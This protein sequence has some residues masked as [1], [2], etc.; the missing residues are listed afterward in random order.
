M[1]SI[2]YRHRCFLVLT[3]ASCAFC[4]TMWHCLDMDIIWSK[5]GASEHS[6]LLRRPDAHS[7]RFALDS[8]YGRNF[9]FPW[10]DRQKG[11]NMSAF[12][13]VQRHYFL[14]T[15]R[16]NNTTR[17]VDSP[18][19]LYSLFEPLITQA[20][21]SFMLRTFEIFVL[22]CFKANISF[23]LY[24]GT[25]LGS[26]RHHAMIPWDDD[27]DVIM[28]ASDK[29][30]IR[31]AFKAVPDYNLFYPKGHQWKF[32]HTGLHTLTKYPF[33]W[34]YIDIFFF[35]ENDTH[36]W[37][38]NKNYMRDFCYKKTDVF[39]LQYRPFEGALLPVPCNIER[40]VRR[41]YDP[42]M[43][44]AATYVHKLEADSR[45]YYSTPCRRLRGLFPFVF[46]TNTTNGK[47]RD[48]LR[49]NG[50]TQH[51]SLTEPYC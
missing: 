35:E 41:T 8:S 11:E 34:P 32:Y 12:G 33:Q 43:C 5:N 20:E 19:D 49:L 47:M 39:P 29:I 26:H 2:K 21:H 9:R 36:I 14:T 44:S 16:G 24:G 3:M 25:L 22:L 18:R 37:D 51:V 13:K 31:E 40:V 10:I 4:F 23:F 1:F 48:E 28:N 38:N 17:T 42:R 7:S 50:V 46:R 6:N 15:R 30:R 27:I 45:K